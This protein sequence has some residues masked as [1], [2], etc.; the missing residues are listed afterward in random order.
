MIGTRE[1]RHV[2]E[3]KRKGKKKEARPVPYKYVGNDGGNKQIIR[4]SMQSPA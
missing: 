1:T 3:K 2:T 4:A